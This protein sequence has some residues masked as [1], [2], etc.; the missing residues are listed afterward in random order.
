MDAARRWHDRQRT[1]T[2]PPEEHRAMATVSGSDR[3]YPLEGRLGVAFLLPA[4]C[5]AEKQIAE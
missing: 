3:I 4:R 5:V 2:H 1:A